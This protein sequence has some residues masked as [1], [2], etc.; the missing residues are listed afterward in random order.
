MDLYLLGKQTWDDSQLVYHAMARL[1]REGLILLS[2]A[3]PYVCIGFHQDLFKEVDVDFCRNHQIP[4]FRR[5]VG[6]GAVYLD[7]NQL[8]FQMILK[9]DDRRI[10]TSKELFYQKFLQPVIRVYRRVGIPAE[11]KPVNDVI[12][13]NRKI[14]GSGVGEIGSCI[15]FVGNLILDFN[16]EMMAR[17]L[18]VPDEKF[19][20]KVYRTLKENLSTIRQEL[21]DEKSREWNEDRL[22][23]MMVEEFSMLLGPLTPKP[24]DS[25]I[26]IKMEELRRI[27]MNDAWLTGIRR[28]SSTRKVKIRD[29]VHL[30]QKVHK[31]AGGLMRADFEI[32]NSR[33]S[34]ISIS[35][36]FFFYPPEALRILEADLE[37]IKPS[38]LRYLLEAFYSNRLIESPGISIDDWAALFDT[39]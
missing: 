32:Q 26:R 16:H 6:G 17:V 20:D 39:G 4:L 1:G 36:D 15:V 30:F 21:G 3:T 23:R 37:G 28:R 9:R 5:D 13:G 11:Y 22:N 38:D 29:G 34:G 25:G 19:R 18:K 8:F 33:F 14:S 2:P 10:P 31:A 7:G 12:S 35:G 27:M 24:L